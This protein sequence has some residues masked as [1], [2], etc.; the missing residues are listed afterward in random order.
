MH[1]RL[2][3]ALTAWPARGSG[4]VFTP[5]GPRPPWSPA[6]ANL[7]FELRREARYVE[8]SLRGAL[9]LPIRDRGTSDKNTGI[10]LRSILALAEAAGTQRALDAARWLERWCGQAA[11]VLGE[12]SSIIRLP[13]QPGERERPCPFCAGFTL[14]YWP[15]HGVVRCVNPGCRDDEGRRPAAEITYSSFT[16]HLELLWQDGVL[17]LPELPASLAR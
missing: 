14:R 12:A 5:P 8:R 1:A 9:S 6:A 10:A 2:E 11:R 3:L 15:L 7:V 16:A 4:G 17:G 13:R